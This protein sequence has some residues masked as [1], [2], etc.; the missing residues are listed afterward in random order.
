M[1]LMMGGFYLWWTRGKPVGYG[2]LLVVEMKK[3]LMMLFFRKR[4]EKERG[5]WILLDVVWREKK[6]RREIS[7]GSV[8]G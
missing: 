7:V 4:R 3:K 2:C 1:R 6:E 5:L 8:D